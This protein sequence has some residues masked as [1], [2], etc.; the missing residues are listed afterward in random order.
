MALTGTAISTSGDS[1]VLSTTCTT[2]LAAKSKT[3]GGTAVAKREPAK[4]S[5]P[6]SEG[7]RVNVAAYLSIHA[8]RE[9]RAE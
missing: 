6:E 2:S 5:P 8:K 7:C 3:N 1:N 4:P 9:S